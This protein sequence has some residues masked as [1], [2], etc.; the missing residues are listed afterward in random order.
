MV[1]IYETVFRIVRDL[2]L[3]VNIRAGF[4][5][6]LLENSCWALLWPVFERFMT[7]FVVGFDSGRCCPVFPF[8][9]MTVF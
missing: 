6:G 7:G 2:V 4:G 5:S 1:E 3:K 9:P 8:D